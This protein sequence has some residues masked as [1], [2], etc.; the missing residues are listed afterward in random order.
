MLYGYTVDKY[1]VG[2][3]TVVAD[4]VM[5]TAQPPTFPPRNQNDTRKMRG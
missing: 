4:R 1:T 2:F 3:Y 5:I